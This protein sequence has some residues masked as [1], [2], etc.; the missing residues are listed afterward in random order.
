MCYWIPILVFEIAKVLWLEIASKVRAI[1]TLVWSFLTRKAFVTS[2]E[3]FPQR[4]RRVFD[5]EVCSFLIFCHEGPT[6]LLERIAWSQAQGWWGLK[7][8]LWLHVVLAPFPSNTS[9]WMNH[10]IACG[11][12]GFPVVLA[13]GP[14]TPGCRKRTSRRLLSPS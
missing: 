11:L 8:S 13:Q 14:S 7:V 1:P 5:P 9:L 12:R 6:S 2:S 10:R 3:F 4:F